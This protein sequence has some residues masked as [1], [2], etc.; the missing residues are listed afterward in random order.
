MSATRT[1]VNSEGVDTPGRCP[2][3]PVDGQVELSNPGGEC[4][5]VRFDGPVVRVRDSKNAPRAIALSGR[6][7]GAFLSNARGN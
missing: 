2:T 4:V 6:A 1:P 7:W 5:E 3:R